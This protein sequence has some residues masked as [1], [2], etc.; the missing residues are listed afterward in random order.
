[1]E[2]FAVNNSS[3]DDHRFNLDKR[4]VT[5]CQDR[6]NYVKY[7]RDCMSLADEHKKIGIFIRD[8]VGED[9]QRLLAKAEEIV[10]I[11]DGFSF[12]VMGENY[13]D[14]IYGVPEEGSSHSRD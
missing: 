3:I 9:Y 12:L 14:F 7:D 5:E 13:M 6:G 8:Y 2:V 11:E 1:M 4:S 10:P